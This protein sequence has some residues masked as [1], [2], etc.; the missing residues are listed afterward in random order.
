MLSTHTV[1]ANV[2]VVTPSW[3]LSYRN[4]RQQQQHQ[5]QAPLKDLT[6][7]AARQGAPLGRFLRGAIKVMVKI[8]VNI[9]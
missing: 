2:I 1:P 4:K 5:Q 6:N 8:F 3:L 7:N 9:C